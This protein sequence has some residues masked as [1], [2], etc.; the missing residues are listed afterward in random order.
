[1]PVDHRP[2]AVFAQISP[3][4][5][6]RLFLGPVRRHRIHLRKLDDDIALPA[7]Q[8]FHHLPPEEIAQCRSPQVAILRER[9]EEPSRRLVRTFIGQHRFPPE[10]RR[11]VPVDDRSGV[12]LIERPAQPLRVDIGRLLLPGHKIPVGVRNELL[13]ARIEVPIL[14][15]H[16]FQG[17]IFR[18]F[19]VDVK[20]ESLLLS[21]LSPEP[22]LN[23]NSP[24]PVGQAFRPA[25]GLLPG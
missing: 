20:H 8:R 22:R 3:R 17:R 9:I 23:I 16:L 5:P 21:G 2:G 1:M 4:P 19:P 10:Q 18:M 14:R 7:H 24:A 15:P 12:V 13:A 11:P 25:A 6:H